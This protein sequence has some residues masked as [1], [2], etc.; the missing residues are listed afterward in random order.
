MKLAFLSDIHANLHAWRACLAHA[1]A[2]GAEQFAILGDLVGYGASPAAV[3]DEVMALAAAG[4][5]VVGGNHDALAVAP[6]AQARTRDA[7][8]AQWTHD[9]LSRRQLDFLASLPLSMRHQDLHL[10]HASADAP[11]QWRYASESQVAAAS[12]EAACAQGPTF[13]VFGGHVHH[14]LLYFWGTGRTLMRFLP[15]P[16]VA[17]PLSRRRQW[18]ATVGSVGQP[19]DG[20][21]QAMYALLDTHSAQLCF[22]RVEYDYMAAATAIRAMGLPEE[23]A[24]RIELGF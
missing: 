10:V 18:L 15:T 19:R 5:W 4:A 13:C 20:H 7:L 11:A 21:T 16:G 6:P 24:R 22:H 8:G 17:L 23:S 3:V 14:Q 12:L 2:Q 1:K 9:Q